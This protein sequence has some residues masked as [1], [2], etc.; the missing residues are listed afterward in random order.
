MPPGKSVKPKARKIPTQPQP[1]LLKGWKNI[2]DYLGQPIA[3]AQRWGKSGMPIRREGR[4]TAATPADLSRWLGG[5][6]GA[7][8]PV[9]IAAEADTD[10]SAELRKSLSAA[11]GKHAPGR[12]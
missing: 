1:T 3:V 8:E 12:R 6:S 9:H 2:A 7:R 5:E 11:K 4:Y 10:L